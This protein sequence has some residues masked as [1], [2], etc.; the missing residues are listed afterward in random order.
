MH[1]SYEFEVISG[2]T[3]EYVEPIKFNSLYQNASQNNEEQ[4]LY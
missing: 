2:Q 3:R 1:S 4:F